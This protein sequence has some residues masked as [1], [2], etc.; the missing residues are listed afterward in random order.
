MNSS[1]SLNGLG[2]KPI[3]PIADLENSSKYSQ[4]EV[5]CRNKLASFCRLVDL[6]RWSQAIYGHITVTL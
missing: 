2:D 1:L 3:I 5:D 4:E 6:F